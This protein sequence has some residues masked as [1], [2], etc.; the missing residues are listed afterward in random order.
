MIPQSATLR[1]T[2]RSLLPEVRDTLE[3]RLREIVE[4]TAKAFGAKATLTYNRHYPVTRNHERQTDFAVSG[5]DLKSPDRTGS[6]P[7][8]RR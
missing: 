8:R 2:A 5:R 1:G 7:T 3:N 4:N 6:M